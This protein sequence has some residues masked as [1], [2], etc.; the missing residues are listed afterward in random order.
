MKHYLITGGTGLIGSALCRL[1]ASSENH[2]TVL[3]RTPENVAQRCGENT[4]AV[5][6]LQQISQSTP[7]DIVI[8]LA[9]APIAD[10]R[11]STKR[12]ALL[13]SSRIKL[14]Q[15]LVDWMIQRQNKP[16]TL[17]SGSAV[18]WYGDRGDTILNEQS[19]SNDEYTHQLCEKW[20]QAA[21]RAGQVG[22][23]VCIVR[24]GLV[25]SSQGGFLSKMRLPFTLGLGGKLGKGEQFMPWIHIE[26][27]VDILEYL[28]LHENLKGIFNVCSPNPVTNQT[29]TT[30]LAQKLGRPAFFTT[31]AFVLKL[32]L[33]EM[34]RLLLTGQRA[35]PA[36]L[37]KNG[38][39]FHYNDLS[40]ALDNVLT[41]K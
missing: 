28:S 9:G 13:E 11:W 14:T 12:K 19:D 38:F 22:I 6:N 17:I 2:I 29:F 10:K 31:P 18:G 33:G 5:S 41:H 25:L 20:E 40:T 37:I 35:M 21:L 1:L 23:R 16:E 30:T 24:T 36:K 3:S 8:N 32:L 15:D 26:D 39:K 34:S 7:I 27:M 4:V